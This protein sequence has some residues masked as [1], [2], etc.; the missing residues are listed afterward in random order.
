LIDSPRMRLDWV[1]KGG[2]RFYD[3]STWEGFANDS[4][5]P[6][7]FVQVQLETHFPF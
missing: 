7:G 5:H 6:T 3:T 4:F 1:I 2:V